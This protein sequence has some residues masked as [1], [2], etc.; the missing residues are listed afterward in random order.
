MRRY[1]EEQRPPPTLSG[2]APLR[3][4]AAVGM[5]ALVYLLI[6]RMGDPNMWRWLAGGEGGPPQARRNAATPPIPE[7]AGPTH[8]DPD[9][10][11][12]AREE[13]LALADGALNLQKVEMVPYC[14]LVTWVKN[15]PFERLRRLA[16]EDLIY[17]HFYDEPEKHRGE[18]VTLKLDVRRALDAGAA[19][20]DTQLHEAIGVTQQSAGRPYFL[21]V[22]DYPKDMPRGA[23][24]DQRVRFAGYFLKLQG[25]RAAESKPGDPILKAPLLIGRIEWTPP[26]AA[27]EDDSRSWRLGATLLI[28]VGLAIIVFYIF[29]KLKPKKITTLSGTATTATGAVVSIESWLEQSDLNINENERNDE[30]DERGRDAPDLDE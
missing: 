3:L 21:I 19:C 11:A 26:V 4:A 8:Q 1:W 23:S 13:F 17:T 18:L 22:L 9:Q 16:R 6:A 30:N 12:M 25:Y 20:G 24:L 2:S 28:V 29:A 15:Q 27:K 14:R 5:L 10:A 7:S